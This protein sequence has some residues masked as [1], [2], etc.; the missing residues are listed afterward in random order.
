MQVKDAIEKLLADAEEL[1]ESITDDNAEVIAV[2]IIQAY[3]TTYSAMLMLA[4]AV[5][6]S[7]DAQTR[8][9]GDIVRKAFEA[10]SAWHDR[11]MTA[12]AFDT[13][14]PTS[15]EALWQDFNEAS[16]NG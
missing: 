16:D 15:D 11:I 13:H 3:V 6:S 4:A 14:V 8:S 1:R 2:H 9:Y 12:Q 5:E 7:S 10:D